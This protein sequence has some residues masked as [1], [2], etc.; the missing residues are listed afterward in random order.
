MYTQ[1]T[2]LGIIVNIEVQTTYTLYSINDRTATLPCR[3]WSHNGDGKVETNNNLHTQMWVIVTGRVCIY[4]EKHSMTIYDIRPIKNF[5]QIS[6][7]ALDAIRAHQ[8]N[9]M[10]HKDAAAFYKCQQIYN[11]MKFEEWKAKK[12]KN[13]KKIPVIDVISTTGVNVSNTNES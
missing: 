10:K 2:I 8:R 11:Q 1:A 3:V 7:H 5:N 6:F 12:N 4:Q 9:S 13:I